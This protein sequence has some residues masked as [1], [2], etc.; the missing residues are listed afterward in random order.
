MPKSCH[1]NPKITFPQVSTLFRCAEAFSVDLVNSSFCCLLSG[2]CLQRCGCF[3]NNTEATLRTFLSE[4]QKAAESKKH[5]DKLDT[6]ADPPWS[7]APSPAANVL[8]CVPRSYWRL[9]S[10]T[11]LPWSCMRTWVLSETNGCSDTTWT[12]WT[13]CGSNSGSAR[14]QKRGQGGRDRGRCS[15]RSLSAQQP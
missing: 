2:L 12:E 14:G 9:K 8:V 5:A 7:N 3:R 10:P 6:S 1:L 4:E 11:N 15:P 13:H